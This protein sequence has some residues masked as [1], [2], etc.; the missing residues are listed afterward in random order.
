MLDRTRM[1]RVLSPIAGAQS[2]C[3]TD[4]GAVT[5]VSETAR[6]KERNVRSRGMRLRVVSV[7]SVKHREPGESPGAGSLPSKK[8]PNRPPE[9]PL[10][11]GSRASRPVPLHHSL[12]LAVFLFASLSVRLSVCLSVYLSLSLSACLCA[13]RAPGPA[14]PRPP[15]PRQVACPDAQA[16]ARVITLC[17]DL[18][19]RRSR[20]ADLRQAAVRFSGNGDA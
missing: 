2:P 1:Y 14:L 12:R 19:P 4:A 9:S 20:A 16:C 11:R 17:I 15:A 18:E 10:G 6:Y 7:L 13:G 8:P 3:R 5:T